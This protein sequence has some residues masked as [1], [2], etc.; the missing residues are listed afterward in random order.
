[1]ENKNMKIFNK[2]LILALTTLF[3]GAIFANAQKTPDYKITNLKILPFDSQTGEFQPEIK[4]GGERSF[5]NDLA[6]SLFLVVEISGKAGSFE[7]GRNIEIT[8]LEGKKQKAKKLVQ[9]GL[10]GDGGKFFFPVWL[11]AAMCENIK[12]TARITGQKTA[13]TATRTIPFLCGE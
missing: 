13:S 3:A 4:T 9:I 8:V 10:I 6:I 5:F 11:D 1:M 12:I 2:I 7:T